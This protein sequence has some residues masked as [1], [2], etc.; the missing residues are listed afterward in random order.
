M[1]LI[2]CPQ[3]GSDISD[4]AVKCPKC[5]TLL[6]KIETIEEEDTNSPQW[7][8]WAMV[9]GA[10]V[11]VLIATFSFY[12]YSASGEQTDNADS[13]SAVAVV[14]PEEEIV[15]ITPDFIKNIKAYDDLCGFSEGLAAVCKNGKWGY[16]D[17]KGNEVIHPKYMY[18]GK[19]SCGIAVVVENCGLYTRYAKL[20]F[21][22]REGNV[23]SKLTNMNLRCIAYEG[24]GTM[25]FECDIFKDGVISVLQGIGN[26][27]KVEEDGVYVDTNGNK[28]GKPSTDEKAID[29]DYTVFK[30]EET[31]KNGVKEKAGNIVIPAKYFEID[32]SHVECGEQNWIDVPNISN[33][34]VRVSIDDSR[35]DGDEKHLHFIGYADL[36]GNC[37]ISDAEFKKVEESAKAYNQESETSEQ[38]AEEYAQD[39]ETDLDWI[40]GTWR[41]SSAYGTSVVVINGN[42]LTCKIDGD[43]VYKGSYS[44]EDGQI[45][46]GRGNGTAN[47]IPI[48]YNNH[49]LMASSSAAFV[50]D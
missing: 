42:M 7:K 31:G 34:V 1:A 48:D 29:I 39:A 38:E 15:Q 50:K 3:C 10:V 28:V 32:C 11:I 2:K 5:G 14:P 24:D 43:V 23:I 36:K 9:A 26:G 35:E 47:Y 8:K 33:G 41:Y 16:I 12:H 22:D 40:Q 30:D 19:F 44:I 25:F 27:D 46:Y 6:R 18:A 21:I 20:T 4:K 45:I 13:L 49:R 37:T 17:T